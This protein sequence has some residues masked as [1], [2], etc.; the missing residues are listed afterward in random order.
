MPE[1]PKVSKEKFERVI[2]AL[3]NTS[4][5]PMSDIPRKRGPKAGVKKGPEKRK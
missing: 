1:I 3:L 5:M 2:K 4:P